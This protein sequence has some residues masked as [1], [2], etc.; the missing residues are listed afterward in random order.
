M[1]DIGHV[2]AA[3]T[4]HKGGV[5]TG[6]HSKR[7]LSRTFFFLLFFWHAQVKVL[8]MCMYCACRLTFQTNA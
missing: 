3:V 6:G 7:K 2:A 5:E 8:W 4:T 1:G